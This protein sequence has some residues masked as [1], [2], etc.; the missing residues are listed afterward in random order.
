MRHVRTV[1]SQLCAVWLLSSCASL[2]VARIPSPYADDI[3]LGQ[4]IKEIRLEG[5]HA[6]DDWII[7]T[8]MATK[9]GDVYTEESAIVDGRRLYGLGIFTAVHFSTIEEADGAILVVSL[10]E[11]NPYIPAPSIKITEENGLELGAAISST[12]LFGRA[13]RLSAFARGGG[14][15]NLGVKFKEPAL[16]GDAWSIGSLN[17]EYAHMER[18][19]S[20]WDFDEKSDDFFM[21]VTRNITNTL[22]WGPR[23]SLLSV[24]SK[25]PGV[26]LN[27][28]NR[29]YM[30]G[31]G[32][33]LQ[34]DARNLSIYPTDGWWSEL[35]LTYSGGDANY[36]QGTFDYRR[37]HELAGNRHSVALYTLTSLTSGE[38]GV[39]IPD[40]QLFAIGGANTVRGWA[41]GARRGKN[42]F[43]NTLEYW[44]LWI[45]P[46]AY[47]FWFLRQALGIQLALLADL[48]TAWSTEDEFHRNWILG[49]GGGLRITIPASV[50][51]RF[52]LAYGQSGATVGL[53]IGSGEKAEAQRAR[54]R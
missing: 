12:N 23:L 49:G 5:N 51:F 34:A 18:S 43:L 13:T 32:L 9:V 35:L 44:F 47:S 27:T 33:F 2:E 36:W 38:V 28:D 29:D 7:L 52:D 42:Q 53:Y 25:Q 6:T 46:K 17:L 48:G 31:A 40:Y 37:Y 16:P 11:V 14:A 45:E 20:L 21:T 41:L 24:A 3:V 19:N 4:V 1:V 15:L 8:S 50:M 26:T 39:D 54:V 22:R 10:S 30:P